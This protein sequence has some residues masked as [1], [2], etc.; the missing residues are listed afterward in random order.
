LL[1]LE[2]WRLN[3][4]WRQAKD[5]ELAE[6]G[7]DDDIEEAVQLQQDTNHPTPFDELPFDEDEM[8]ADEHAQEQEAEIEALLPLMPTI[9]PSSHF[10]SDTR[11]DTPHFSDDDD[12]DALFMDFISQQ[13]SNKENCTSSQ[14]MDM[15]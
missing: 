10:R 8:M 1:K 3:R 15:S 2:W 5:A 6:F 7:N 9:A 12:Y 13:G 11:P 14:D 4:E